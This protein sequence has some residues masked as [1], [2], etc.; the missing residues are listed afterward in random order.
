MVAAARRAAAAAALSTE[1]V[2][3]RTGMPASAEIDRL[4]RRRRR[5]AVFASYDTGRA[6]RWVILPGFLVRHACRFAGRRL[7]RGEW[8]EFLPGRDYDPAC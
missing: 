4:I 7:T 8:K 5:R 1:R 6:Y 2:G 3:A